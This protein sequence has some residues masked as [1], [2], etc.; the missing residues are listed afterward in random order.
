MQL[1]GCYLGSEHGEIQAILQTVPSSIPLYMHN[2]SNH[3]PNIIRNI[4]ESVKRRL[5]EISSDEAVFNETATPNQEALYKGGY[6]YKLEFKLPER[7]SSQRRHRSR[8]I[9]RFNPPFNKNNK[10]NIGR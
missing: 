8:Q 9:T 6:T 4:S 1:L 7:A 5:S 3:P 2:K 10:S